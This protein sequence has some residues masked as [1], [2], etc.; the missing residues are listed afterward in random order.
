MFQRIQRPNVE[1]ARGREFITKPSNKYNSVRDPRHNRSRRI[2]HCA[3]RTATHRT[4]FGCILHPTSRADTE[5]A[6]PA[7]TPPPSRA[8]SPYACLARRAH[9]QAAR[10]VARFRSPPHMHARARPRLWCLVKLCGVPFA[11]FVL[12]RVKRACAPGCHHNL[13]GHTG[14]TST[15]SQMPTP[16]RQHRRC[17]TCR[18]HR[19]ETCWSARS[20]MPSMSLRTFVVPVNPSTPAPMTARTHSSVRGVWHE[21]MSRKR[22]HFKVTGDTCPRNNR[23][24]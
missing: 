24:T 15:R 1:S 19:C 6:N 23:T 10:G 12:G 13:V 16:R 8:C 17:L 5:S 3:P 9:A 18:R 7:A 21:T 14:A 22:R 4:R 2:P 11:P 20:P